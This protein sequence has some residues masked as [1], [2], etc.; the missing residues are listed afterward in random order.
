MTGRRYI[1]ANPQS[2]PPLPATFAGGW[3][4]ITLSVCRQVQIHV[5]E[6]LA[7]TVKIEREN[8]CSRER[9]RRR[10]RQSEEVRE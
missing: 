4:Q 2:S 1:T 3:K 5:A 7:A 9:E 10:D 6:R 8:R